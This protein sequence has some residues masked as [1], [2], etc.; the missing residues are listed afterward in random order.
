MRS[1]STISGFLSL[2]CFA[3]TTLFAAGTTLPAQIDISATLDASGSP[4]F[5]DGDVT[6][7]AGVTLTIGTGVVVVLAQGASLIVDGTLVARGTQA[8]P[9]TF[10]PAVADQPWTSIRFSN[11]STD[12]VLDNAANYS[13]GSILE[14]V[15]VSG[16]G[17]GGAAA[18]TLD[19]AQPYLS[20]LDVE[21]MPAG[22]IRG[23]GLDGTLVL[24]DS[25]IANNN[26]A[27]TA[28]CG[29]VCLQGFGSVYPA[30]LLLLNNDISGNHVSDQGGGVKLQAFREADIQDNRISNNFSVLGGGGIFIDT[31]YA[32]KSQ[33]LVHGNQLIKNS[34]L[35]P[36]QASSGGGLTVINANIIITN[37]LIRDNEADT[38]GGLWYMGNNPPPASASEYLADVTG[39]VFYNNT[40]H[41]NAGGIFV[42]SIGQTFTVAVNIDGNLLVGNNIADQISHGGAIDLHNGHISI[43][44][45]ILADNTAHDYGGAIN[46]TADGSGNNELRHNLIMGNGSYSSVLKLSN[47]FTVAA[48]TVYRNL[49]LSAAAQSNPAGAIFEFSKSASS[50]TG[51]NFAGN[52]SSLLITYADANNPG[53]SLSAANN[54]WDTLDTKAIHNGAF[55]TIDPIAGDWLS[56]APLTPPDN[57]SIVNDNNNL[58]LRWDAN[59][60]ANVAGYI[61]Y[62]GAPDGLQFANAQN[63]G[64][65][66]SH[67]LQF[68]SAEAL[69]VAVA[70]YTDTYNEAADNPAT[71]VNEN[72]TSGSQSWYSKI[73]TASADT[74]DLMVD[75]KDTP[76]LLDLN[77]AFGFT[78]VAKNQG[79]NPA[80]N[81]N[82][83]INPSSTGVIIDTIPANCV[84]NTESGAVTCHVDTLNV[85]SVEIALGGVV[86]GDVTSAAIT[87]AIDSTQPDFNRADN[88][89]VLNLPLNLPDQSG[90]QKKGSHKKSKSWF[91]ALDPALMVVLLALL[92]VR[93]GSGA[94]RRRAA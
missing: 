49:I 75:F 57:F 7:K 94:A 74:A 46:S 67:T 92:A 59:P 72:Q 70:A 82:I 45:N 2:L 21:N 65:T 30:K 15:I 64:N 52:S 53:S 36:Q 48:N 90:R 79:P 60:Q 47:S 56:D 22:G 33:N 20:H 73:L 39:N 18:I 24:R 55:V 34:A 37:N 83:N 58:T 17:N 93:L 31:L 35:S 38:G 19:R 41:D 6:V 63:V 29:G 11:A 91:G 88:E 54:W 32:G 81:V 28:D 66:T 80:Q 13:G 78:L 26:A 84:K 12:A 50:V 85:E 62:W 44:N 5:A 68:T 42:N 61:V 4:Y 23:S 25:V 40:A 51:N 8:K 87:A 14:Y 16:A 27:G 77:Q 89:K 43:V 76:A 10:S 69:N 1:R 86:T 71:L 9:I 3:P